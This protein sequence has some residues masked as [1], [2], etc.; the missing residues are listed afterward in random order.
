VN[1]TEAGVIKE[2]LVKEED[3]V[4][5]GQDLVRI[6]VGAEPGSKA[7]PESD[8]KPHE[9]K[10]ESK[11]DEAK[12]AEEGSKEASTPAPKEPSP[13][14]KPE[15]KKSDAPKPSTPAPAESAGAT[16]STPGGREER[17]VW[18]STSTSLSSNI[19]QAN[20]MGSG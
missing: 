11:A 17:R 14:P 7:A 15:P 18:I 13:P 16:P 5:V 12:P 4:T 3:T 1:A 9:A 2:L 8:S 19:F 20:V 6:E 10:P